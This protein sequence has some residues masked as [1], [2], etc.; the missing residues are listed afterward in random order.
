M[1]VKIIFFSIIF[2]STIIPIIATYLYINNNYIIKIYS[3]ETDYLSAMQNT[4]IINDF[5]AISEQQLIKTS[6]IPENDLIYNYDKTIFQF[7]MPHPY[8]GFKS[9]PNTKAIMK[10][11]DSEQLIITNSLGHRSPELG[12]KNNR[13]LR[14]AMIGGSTAFNGKTNND[15]IIAKLAQLIEKNKNQPVEFVNAAIV[16]GNSEQELAVFVHELMDFNLDLLISFDGLNDYINAETAIARVRWPS[17][18]W[19]GIYYPY[20]PP[21][22]VK[23][24][25][26]KNV[27]PISNAYIVN[28][29]KIALISQ[30][31][32]I[33][34]IA[35]LQPLKEYNNSICNDNINFPVYGFYCVTERQYDD[36]NEIHLYN[37]S[38]ISFATLLDKSYFTDI[39][40]LTDDGNT[41]IAQSLYDII[42]KQEL[43]R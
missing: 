7:Q 22:T 15:T 39:V 5:S 30:A 17:M 16:S 9:Q 33:S 38:Y 3:K 10:L 11:A 21:L 42:N 37:A 4:K 2:I 1:I 19:N 34:Y 8:A 43:L 6:N 12:I 24:V 29:Q 25:T 26:P 36:M 41:I 18:H 13:T 27:L 31:M 23:K 40:H 32:N 14:I 20:V 28:L 35:V